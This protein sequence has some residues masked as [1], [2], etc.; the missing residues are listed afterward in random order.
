RGNQWD[1]LA[2]GLTRWSSAVV[3]DHLGLP[4]R[5]DTRTRKTVVELAALEHVWVKVSA[6][7]RSEVPELALEELLDTTGP[8]RM[9]F[10]SDWPFTGHERGRS[11]SD[12]MTWARTHVG[13][14]TFA[15]TL[16]ANA[17][18]LLRWD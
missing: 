4:H 12:L 3:I 1:E 11:I 8:A 6:P 9:L 5:D 16:P 15:A 10:G 7:Y 2:D 14:D 18:R 17:E 13:K